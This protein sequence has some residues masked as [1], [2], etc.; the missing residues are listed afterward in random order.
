MSELQQAVTEIL[1]RVDASGTVDMHLP[2]LTI[3]GVG[4][5][6]LPLLPVQA[7]ALIAVAEQAPYGRGT[8]TLVDTDVRRTWQIDAT[9]IHI[10]GRRWAEDLDRIV[11]AVTEGLG[12]RGEVQAEPYKL[13]LYDTGSFFVSH[14]DTEKAPGMFATLVLALPSEYRGGELVIR[15]NSEEVRLDL[16]CDDPSEV[17][18]AAFYADCRHEVLPVEGGYRWALVYNLLRPDGGPLPEAPDH[19]RERR[20][21]AERLRRWGEADPEAAL[22]HKL[23][24]PL[25]HSYTEAGLGFDALKGVD[26]AV[27]GVVLAAA[28]DAHCDLQLALVTIGESGWA[29]YTGGGYWDDAEPEFEIGEVDDT[30]RHVHTWRLPDGSNPDMGHLP[31]EDDEVCPPDAFAD[32]DSVEP[33]FEEATGNAGATFERLYQRAALVVWP[34]RRRA[35]VLAQGGI[36]VSVPYLSNLLARLK[37]ERDDGAAS[38]NHDE[39]RQQAF[40]LAAWIRKSW[41]ETGY[42]RLQASQRGLS[43]QLLEAL[44]QLDEADAGAAFIAEVCADGGYT[45]EDNEAILRAC[46]GLPAE[47]A[48]S[49]LHL[50]IAGN[51]PRDPAA[52]AQLLARCTEQLTGLDGDQ[53]RPAALALLAALP[54]GGQT[55]GPFASAPPPP[56]PDL[57]LCAL[58]GL[59]RVDDD[60]ADR[61]LRH[62][63]DRPGL[64]DQ[65]NVL[66]PAA[67]AFASAQGS[68][69]SAA[70]P[71]ALAGLRRT[72]LRRLEARIAEP[73]APP[74]DWQRPAEIRCRC[75]DCTELNRFLASPMEPSWRLKA[76]EPKRRHVEDSIRTHR[77]DVD[78]HT[79]TVGRP[80][81]LV[82]TKNQA[83]YERRVEQ[84]KKDLANRER[85]SGAGG[86]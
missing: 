78:T 70:E 74:P 79:D 49:L 51:A 28:E 63:L 30:W 3:D 83:S 65:D 85:L 31:F 21:L 42:E 27:A 19:D 59:S 25:E 53:L 4:T 17:A 67:L 36:K 52:C 39:L 7:E 43:S 10:S 32:M 75:T 66:L 6:A 12:V 11:H 18:Y 50:V 44:C 62:C 2:G 55:T 8:E 81:T 47:R 33:D 37:A 5:L 35:P 58:L 38:T 14:R 57:V 9:R 23:I 86:G 60:L 56:S 82:C 61:A 48:A 26:A 22:P 13:L 16:R 54:A 64:Y 41:P 46:A 24:Y 71:P 20:Q 69:P 72:V 15:H 80:Y 45:A 77:C 40:E 84:R 1:S 68:S 73:L 76:A 29:E 34:R